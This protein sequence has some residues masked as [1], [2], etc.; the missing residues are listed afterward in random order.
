[1]RTIA[2]YATMKNRLARSANETNSP[3]LK[4]E[5][6]KAFSKCDTS[7]ARLVRYYRSIKVWVIIVNVAVILMMCKGCHTVGGFG[8]D[9]QDWTHE[10]TQRD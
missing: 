1:M 10:Y 7:I 9:L 8:K 5:L 4:A 2:Y 6:W 3:G